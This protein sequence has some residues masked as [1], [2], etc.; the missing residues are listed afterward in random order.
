MNPTVAIHYFL[1]LRQAEQMRL[2][3]SRLPGN[4]GADCY[5]IENGLRGTHS[6]RFDPRVWD[7]LHPGVAHPD[8][9]ILQGWVRGYLYAVKTAKRT[10][11][12]LSV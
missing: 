8:P 7:R 10:L 4:G 12:Q 3:V 11:R 9:V 5:L 2:L 6:L 1:S